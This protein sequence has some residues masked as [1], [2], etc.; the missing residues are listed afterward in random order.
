MLI[1]AYLHCVYIE[2]TAWRSGSGWL[3]GPRLRLATRATCPWMMDACLLTNSDPGS[4][5]TRPTSWYCSFTSSWWPAWHGDM[6]HFD[7]WNRTEAGIAAVLMA[8]RKS[9]VYRCTWSYRHLDR[10]IDHVHSHYGPRSPDNDLSEDATPSGSGA[11]A[12]IL[13]QEASQD[14]CGCHTDRKCLHRWTSSSPTS[15][16]SSWRTPLCQ[17]DVLPLGILAL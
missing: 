9:A 16:S 6:D 10:S 14:T 12:W 2:W 7:P 8:P 3:Y 15:Y 1:N 4:W 11:T 5:L 17:L 13:L